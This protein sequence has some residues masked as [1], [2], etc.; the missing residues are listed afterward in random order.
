MAN[1]ATCNFVMSFAVA[2]TVHC[3]SIINSLTAATNGHTIRNSIWNELQLF[4]QVSFVY[5]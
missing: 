1:F 3:I 4:F 5:L 2:D